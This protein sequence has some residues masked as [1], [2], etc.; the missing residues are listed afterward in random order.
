MDKKNF[1]LK[2]DKEIETTALKQIV[3][4]LNTSGG[5]LIIGVDDEQ[6]IIQDENGE[7]TKVKYDNC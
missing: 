1:S 3:A 6:N 2:T 7:V 4:F 5:N